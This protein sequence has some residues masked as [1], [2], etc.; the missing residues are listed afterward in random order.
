MDKITK[1]DLNNIVHP[2][3]D[4]KVPL[5]IE[6]ARFPITVSND[7]FDRFVKASS[8][9]GYP[10]VETWATATLIQSLTTKVGHASIDSPTQVSGVSAQKITGPSFSG[11]VT[12][13]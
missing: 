6:E 4:K 11:M 7:I 2:S 12:R 10:S 3:D 5:N 13:G 9:M 1:E 8:H